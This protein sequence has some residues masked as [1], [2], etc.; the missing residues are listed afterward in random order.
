MQVAVDDLL[1]LLEFLEVGLYFDGGHGLHLY[2]GWGGWFS[3][4]LGGRGGGKSGE[5]GYC[6]CAPPHHMVR[7][8][9][10]V[11]QQLKAWCR[12]QGYILSWGAA[13]A[14]NCF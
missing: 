8:L 1:Q 6:G 7:V 10:S 5:G 2:G 13:I 3:I 12:I 14:R 11:A 9:I 4:P